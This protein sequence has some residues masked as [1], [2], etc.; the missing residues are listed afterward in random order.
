MNEI[1]IVSDDLSELIMSKRRKIMINNMEVS[2][3][4]DS[5]ILEYM[6]TNQSYEIDDENQ[7]AQFICTSGEQFTVIF[8]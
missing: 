4:E 1:I 2:V 7:E 5:E 6:D 3:E 8:F